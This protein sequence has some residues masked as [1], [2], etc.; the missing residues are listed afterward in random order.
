MGGDGTMAPLPPLVE[1]QRLDQPT[2]HALYEA[3][4]PGTR[5]ELINGVVYMPSPVG[6]RAW[7][8]P[9]P[10]DRVARLLRRADTRRRRSWTTPR[11]SWAGR[12]SPSPMCCFASSPSSAARPATRRDISSGPPKLVVEV[13]QSTRYVDLGPEAGGL[14]AARRP[15][16]RRPRARARRGLLVRPAEGAIRWSSDRRRRTG[17]TARWS[18]PGSGSIPRRSSGATGGASAPWSTSAAPRPSTRRSSP[19]WRPPGIRRRD[20]ARPDRSPRSP[21]AHRFSGL[22]LMFLNQQGEPWSCRPM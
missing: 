20:R 18:S 3:M 6:H 9:R 19:G 15:G 1:G 14:R 22:I 8:G 17:S 5:A 7:P 11:R 2:F 4:P 21:A 13:A 10:G 12:A 16:I